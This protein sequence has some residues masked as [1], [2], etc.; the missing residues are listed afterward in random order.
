M[1]DVAASVAMRNGPAVA[2]GNVV[3]GGI[4]SRGV[5]MAEGVVSRGEGIPAGWSGGRLIVEFP[6]FTTLLI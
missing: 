5:V 3:A 2:V 1:D 6:P 4:A